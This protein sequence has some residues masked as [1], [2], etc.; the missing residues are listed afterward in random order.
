[1]IKFEKPKADEDAG[2]CFN[3]NNQTGGGLF[4]SVC[5]D[6][7]CP[8]I[9]INPFTITASS[10]VKTRDFWSCSV[11]SRSLFMLSSLTG[12]WNNEYL[13]NSLCCYRSFLKSNLQTLFKREAAYSLQA[14]CLYFLLN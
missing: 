8:K 9:I 14:I 7:Q 11:C 13:Y 5:K 10:A 3:S 12:G 4:H 1:M 2:I 6:S